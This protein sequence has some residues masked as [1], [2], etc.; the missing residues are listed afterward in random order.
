MVYNRQNQSSKS[1]N[2]SP[3]FGPNGDP[4]RMSN[5]VDAAAAGGQVKEESKESAKPKKEEKPVPKLH[6]GT[7]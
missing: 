3:L 2:A 1:N 4:N 5:A 6:Q 7:V